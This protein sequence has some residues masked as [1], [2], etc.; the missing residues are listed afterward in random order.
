MQEEAAAPSGSEES[1]EMEVEL[2]PEAEEMDLDADEGTEDAKPK[3]RR[4]CGSEAAWPAGVG[5]IAEAHA[6]SL[7]RLLP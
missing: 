2:D 5:A 7:W 4:R 1:M 3:K 6:G